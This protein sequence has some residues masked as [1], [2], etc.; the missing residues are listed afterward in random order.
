MFNCRSPLQTMNDF[1]I[2]DQKLN[3]LINA[4]LPIKLLSD[5][6]P[7]DLP[8]IKIAVYSSKNDLPAVLRAWLA[9]SAKGKDQL[10]T[11]ISK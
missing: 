3:L 8:G 4:D 10:H 11:V 7:V 6:C 9:V 2:G 5:G 1:E